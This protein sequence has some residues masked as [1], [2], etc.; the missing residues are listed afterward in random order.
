MQ[1]KNKRTNYI[2][3]RGQLPLSIVAVV[4]ITVIINIVS[5]LEI[6]NQGLTWQREN[7]KAGLLTPNCCS[8]HGARL[9][10]RDNNTYHLSEGWWHVGFPARPLGS[11]G[12]D[13]FGY[14]SLYRQHGGPRRC[15]S[16]FHFHGLE[17]VKMKSSL[18]NFP[19]T[20]WEKGITL[21]SPNTGNAIISWFDKDRPLIFS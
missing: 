3:K 19:P 4:V 18:R 15:W 10:H 16:Q 17:Y 1:P 13:S 6:R 21:F 9:T 14:S 2:Q 8:F 12:A 7:Q 5:T 11:Y 20:T